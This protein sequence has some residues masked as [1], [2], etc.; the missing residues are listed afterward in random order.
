MPSFEEIESLI[1]VSNK[2]S[3]WLVGKKSKSLIEDGACYCLSAGQVSM[4]Y[5]KKFVT[6]SHTK[7]QFFVPNKFF[8]VDLIFARKARTEL[9][10]FTGIPRKQKTILK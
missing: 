4:L 6:D 3:A 9:C 5:K 8:Q 2:F 10:T 1:P 7:R